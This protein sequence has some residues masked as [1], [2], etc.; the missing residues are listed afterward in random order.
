MVHRAHVP[1]NADCGSYIVP[2][3]LW[4]KLIG[5]LYHGPQDMEMSDAMFLSR[6]FLGPST[7]LM[8]PKFVVKVLLQ[9]V[10]GF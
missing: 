5:L 3:A 10:L 8:H 9:W 1:Y 4:H 6:N 2:S 7:D